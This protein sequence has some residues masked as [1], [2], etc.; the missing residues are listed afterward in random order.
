MSNITSLYK[1]T[2]QSRGEFYCEAFS[3]NEAEDTLYNFYKSCNDELI[4]Q[5]RVIKIEKIG[6]KIVGMENIV[7][8]HRK[9]I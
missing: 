4:V 3:Y 2:T 8:L 1:I 6:S 9:D 5:Y 7:G